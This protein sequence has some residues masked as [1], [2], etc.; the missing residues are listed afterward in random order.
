VTYHNCSHL[1]DDPVSLFCVPTTNR[2]SPPCPSPH[3][4]GCGHSRP[5][6]IDHTPHTSTTC[7]VDHTTSTTRY[8]PCRRQPRHINFDHNMSTP[9]RQP[10]PHQLRH[11]DVDY[12]TLISATTRRCRH[13]NRTTS[14]SATYPNDES[15]TGHEKRRA[16]RKWDEE[17]VGL[18]EGGGRT[19]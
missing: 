16:R 14:T 5:H 9:S 2:K 15:T 19:V 17:E 1:C 3:V 13:D 12:P 11:V 10:P 7:H 6:P 8:I 4:E 18:S